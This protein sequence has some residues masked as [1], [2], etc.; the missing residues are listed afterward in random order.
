MGELSEYRFIETDYGLKLAKI[1][2]DPETGARTFYWV[3]TDTNVSIEAILK[4]INE[5][6]D[7]PAI[8]WK[9]ERNETPQ[10]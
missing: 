9:D 2:T 5:A 6:K 1:D 10:R 3:P 8:I 4:P 7:K